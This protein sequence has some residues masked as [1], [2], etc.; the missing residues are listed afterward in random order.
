MLPTQQA[1]NTKLVNR[2]SVGFVIDDDDIDDKV[3]LSAF[4]YWPVSAV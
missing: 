4:Y 2:S 3:L 1:T